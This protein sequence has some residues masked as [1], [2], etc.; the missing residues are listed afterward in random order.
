MGE[1]RAPLE[2]EVLPARLVLDDHVGAHDVAGHEIGR[3]LDARKGQL[4]ALRQRL[5]EQGLAETGDAFEQHVSAGEET[6]EHVIDHVIVAD[7]DL[8]DLG[9]EGLEAGHE[10]LDTLFLTLGRHGRLRH[11]RLLSASW[12]Q[13]TKDF[14]HDRG[15][16]P[17]RQLIARRGSRSRNMPIQE[18]G[19]R[20]SKSLT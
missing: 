19:T 12:E 20:V 14:S 10:L 11:S 1:D 16:S 18:A 13:R 4:E 3:E 6:G 5:D 7:D 15:G 2:L 17:I 9:A 8:A